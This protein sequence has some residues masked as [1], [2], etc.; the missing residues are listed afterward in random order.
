MANY[1]IDSMTWS[2]SRIGSYLKCPYQFYMK[3][4]CGLEEAPM[5][6]SSFGS[7]FHSLLAG[8]Y[9]GQ[10]SKSDA[11]TKYLLGYSEETQGDAP[12]Y[13]MR[14]SFFEQGRDAIASISPIPG[15]VMDVEQ[16][17]K[18]DVGDRPFIGFVDLVYKSK[19]G[20][21]VIMDHKSTALKPR[22]KRQ[23]PTLTDQ[24]LDSY[25]RQLYLY[26][27]P[28]QA[29]YGQYPDFLEFNCYRT[30]VVI[31]EQFQK[32]ALD[33]TCSWALQTIDQIAQEKD[34]NPNLD[35]WQCHF[36]CGY[37]DQCEYAQ[38]NMS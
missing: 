32:A 7:F 14:L 22:S 5:F 2:Y 25:L 13:D 6:F 1:R 9:S 11:E 24:N 4:I 36:I 18:F 10:L 33:E 19:D 21:L 12:S 23:K 15:Q 31:R 17:V 8:Y 30:G 38:M 34:W 16:F 26:S 28:I 27:I 20:A 37:C 35:W 29:K 3:Y